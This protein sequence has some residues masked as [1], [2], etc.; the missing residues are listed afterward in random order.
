MK[1]L[2]FICILALIFCASRKDKDEEYE[3]PSEQLALISIE[4]MKALS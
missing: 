2:A 4:N 3:V 1:N